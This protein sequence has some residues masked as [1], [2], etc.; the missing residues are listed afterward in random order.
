[1]GTES[2]ATVDFEAFEKALAAAVD[3]ARSLEEIEAW[4]TSQPA[5]VS[6]RLADYLL[7]SNPPQRD[8]VVEFRT[9]DDSTVTKVVNVFDLGDQ[10]FRFHKLRDR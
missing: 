4:L 6:V 10:R 9:A 5:A 3:G 1:M 8:F 7:K 2:Q